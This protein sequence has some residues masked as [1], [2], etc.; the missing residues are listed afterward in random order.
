M[1]E[2]GSR[3]VEKIK[4]YKRKAVER[5]MRVAFLW[6][7]LGWRRDYLEHKLGKSILKTIN[8]EQYLVLFEEHD[9]ELVFGV[10]HGLFVRM[11]QSIIIDYAF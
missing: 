10:G 5:Q 3:E 11:G 4:R 8:P 1:Q 7:G 2:P 6:L 9:F